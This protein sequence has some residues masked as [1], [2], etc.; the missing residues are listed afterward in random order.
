MSCVGCLLKSATFIEL[1]VIFHWLASQQT[2]SFLLAFGERLRSSCDFR[3][4]TTCCWYLK[5]PSHIT[6]KNVFMANVDR[7]KVNKG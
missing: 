2:N 6:H 5:A 3:S 1:I 7:F 4:I